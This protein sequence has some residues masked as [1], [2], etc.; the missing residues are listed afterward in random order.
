M[1]K[2]LLL[3]L[4]LGIIPSTSITEVRT[5]Y[6]E[7]DQSWFI[8][9]SEIQAAF[10]IDP[11]GHFHAR[12]I[13]DVLRRRVWRTP[14][15]EMSAPINMTVDGAALDG[16]TV[17]SVVSHSFDHIDSP[18]DGV[19]LSVILS[20][21]S[22][23][24]EIRFEAD[25]YD[26]QPFL[27]YRTIYNNTSSVSSVVTRADMLGWNFLDRAE[28]YRD[29]Y[30]GQW[31]YARAANFEPHETNI[32][33]QGPS[34]M[35][36]GAYADH[37]AWRAIRDS[38]DFG[39][40]AAWEFDGRAYANVQHDREQRLLRL[41]AQIA[42]LNHL[43]DAGDSFRVPDAFIGVFRGD[44]DEAGN[45]TRR[46]AEKVLAAPMPE[47]EKVPYVMF[48]TWG[49]GEDINDALVRAAAQ[50]AAELGV[51]V[52]ILDLGWARKI[53]DWRANPDKFPN[54]I[55]PISD[56]VHSLGMKFGLHLPLF[57]AARDAEVLEEHPD[58]EAIDPDRPRL[59]FDATSLCPSHQPAREWII[60]EAIR[61]IRLYRVD[62]VKL[63]GENMVKNCNSTEHTHAA[64]DS[65]YS[66]AVDGL[67]YIMHAIQAATPG[68]LFE[69]CEDG[70]SMQTFHMIQHFVTSIVNDADDALTT[71]RGV[72]GATYPFPIRYTQRY[73][74]DE[75]DNT[76]RTRSYMFGGPFTVMN[77]I[78][79]WP[80][81]TIE[82][83]Q[84]EIALY[85]ALRPLLRD[86]EIHHV[87]PAPNGSSNDA[88]QALEPDQNRGVIFV[89]GD[90][91]K[92]K[93]TYIEPRGLDP[94]ALYLVGFLE[95]KR[96]YYATGAEL[97]ERGIPV[98]M[99]PDMAE[100]ISIERR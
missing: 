38:R 78:T 62:W 22:M 17:Y 11:D 94:N 34:S 92:A 25:V 19:R 81:A 7:E 52:F 40:I 90:E 95:V 91:D 77:R 15:N 1:R 69:N 51:E 57:E 14:D 100:V 42:E 9:N 46:F 2:V 85:K 82:F 8:G 67:D 86:A 44:W 45:E 43:V 3:T 12:W 70:G 23:T 54:G 79:R 16:N 74:M 48:D 39:L 58:W 4:L 93:V 28:T 84:N 10:Q 68:V 55:R 50:R 72:Y 99:R 6:R 13:Y 31:K 73:M 56:Y 47:P 96:S 35:F 27:R 33:F 26:G 75:P 53:G 32:S 20:T 61:A 65:N 36:T 30:V 98:I 18:A 37:S 21:Q 88:I 71:R 60:S 76:Y 59:Y 49:Y 64:G 63:D 66:N 24:G 83:V 29:F 5:A 87:T 97:M 41:D 80:T 89:Y